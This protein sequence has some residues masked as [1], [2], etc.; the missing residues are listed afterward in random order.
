MKSPFI[1]PVPYHNIEFNMVDIP[2]IYFVHTF[3]SMIFFF[4]IV[5]EHKFSLFHHT[6]QQIYT[7]MKCRLHKLQLPCKY[8]ITVEWMNERTHHQTFREQ[9]IYTHMRHAWMCGNKLII[10]KRRGWLW[11]S[12]EK[13]KSL[14]ANG[15]EKM[16][17]IYMRRISIINVFW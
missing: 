4:C 5:Y 6:F 2:H 9:S 12:L 13:E 1:F 16:E 11:W 3:I 8:L 17:F 14:L 15:N 7:E 10:K